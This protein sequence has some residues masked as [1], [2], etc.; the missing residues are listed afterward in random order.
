MHE[1]VTT[2][3]VIFS[4]NPDYIRSNWSLNKA[5]RYYQSGTKLR[6]DLAI[7]DMA[8]MW[9]FVPGAASDTVVPDM[10]INENTPADVV[11]EYYKSR[12]EFDPASFA[13]II[14]DG[15]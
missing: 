7:I 6:Q 5:I 12:N 1:I 9:G 15:V 11:I 3:A 10:E 13:D 2:L 14:G 8:P 4:L